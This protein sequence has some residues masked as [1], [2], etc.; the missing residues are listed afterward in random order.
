ME[1][2]RGRVFKRQYKKLDRGLRN[3]VTERLHLLGFDEFN[4]LLRNHQLIGEYGGFR[5]INITGD[6]R[7]VYRKIGLNIY[8]LRAVGTHHQLFGT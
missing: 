8:Q 6:L 2:K 5:S 1:F 4:P 7:L 3:K